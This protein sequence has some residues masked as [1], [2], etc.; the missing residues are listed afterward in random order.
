MENLYILLM[1]LFDVKEMSILR[2]VEREKVKMGEREIRMDG[3]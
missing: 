3:R 1:T 2:M